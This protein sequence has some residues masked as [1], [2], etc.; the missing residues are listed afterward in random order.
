ME[1]S[2]KLITFKTLKHYI[3]KKDV[4]KI[5]TLFDRFHTIDLAHLF[6][7]LKK[8]EDLLFVFRTC[9]ADHT[10][11]LFS[12]LSNEQQERLLHI[13]TDK[14]LVQLLKDSYQD[15]IADFLSDLPANLVSKILRVTDPSL[16][17]EIN[18]L[19]NYKN[20]TA[21]S[22]MTTEYITI[23]ETYR[24]AEALDKI[25]TIGKEKET[26]YSNFVTDENRFLKGILT[27][28]DVVFHD[29]ASM[30]RDVMKKD[31]IFCSV[32][33]DQEE[34]SQLFQR[35]DLA[36]MPVLN[37]S[38]HLVGIITI[39]D[40]VDVIEKEASEDFLKMAAIQPLEDSYR[41]TNPFTLVKKSIPWVLGLMVVGAISTLTINQ[42]QGT[43]ENV[44]ILTAFIP[45]I[46]NTGGNTGNQSIAIIT[47]A[48]AVKD[49]SSKDLRFVFHKEFKI[50]SLTAVVTALFT[51][52]FIFLELIT[53]FIRLPEEMNMVMYEPIWWT[54]ILRI[55]GL[56]S[57]TLLLSILISKMLG[58]MLPLMALKLNKD[59]AVM[60]SPF[61]TTL[62]DFSSLLIY[63][64]LANFVFNFF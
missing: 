54:Y 45:A 46:M 6:N 62:V 9:H 56:V 55:S 39:D 38:N 42:F 47:R 19:L 13:F 51:F 48:I 31:F 1:M 23:P 22:I 49:I 26:I 52:S 40:V 5:R 59:P 61:L 37:E 24:I 25:R 53:G 64:L 27:I 16:R 50:A 18:T 41:L 44:L 21:G 2:Y 29:G 43:L 11:S 57:L 63:F 60:S 10:A 35:Y 20:G 4:K 12:H 7:Q 34:V 28:E 33:Q 3:S 15:D 30:V 14:Q 36:V 8:P 32:H 58:A 17:Q